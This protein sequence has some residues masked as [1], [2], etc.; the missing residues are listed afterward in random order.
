MKH[1]PEWTWEKNDL[2][3]NNL[4]NMYRQVINQYLRYTLHVANNIGSVY[5]TWKTIEQPGDIYT[6]EPKAKQKEAV[7]FLQKEV[8]ATPEW[9]LDNTIL[10][11]LSSPVRMGSVGT[12][13][14]R[15]LDLILNDRVLTALLKSEDRYGKDSTYTLPEYLSDLQSGIWSELNTHKPIDIFRRNVQ[16]NYVNNLF[17]SVK[18]AEEG[19]N[20]AGML[21]GIPEEVAPITVG[22]DVGSYLALHLDNLRKEI[23][24]AMPFF[25]DKESRDHLKFVADQIKSGLEKRFDILVK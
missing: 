11:K 10:D 17:A 23:L 25:M 9:L 1:L 2:Y 6:A 14:T 5:E 19:R 20:F 8:F 15:A 24:K 7:A 18:E 22:S 16:K 3:S 4:Q 21:L 13:Q 12:V